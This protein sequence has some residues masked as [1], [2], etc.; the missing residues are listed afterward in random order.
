V[1][2]QENGA[3]RQ[4]QA[5]AAD[6]AAAMQALHAAQA[7][8]QAGN[9]AFQARPHGYILLFWAGLI[10]RYPE[11]PHPHCVVLPGPSCQDELRAPL[12][13]TFW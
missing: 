4:E 7:R 1:C 9:A 5:A 6:A 8:K 11:V 3:L 10:S 2:A 13:M 12:R